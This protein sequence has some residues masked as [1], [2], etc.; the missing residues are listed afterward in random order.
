MA[1][2]LLCVANKK[3]KKGIKVE[4]LSANPAVITC[5]ANDR[6]YENIFSEQLNAKG[7]KGDLLLILSG[8]GNSKNVIKAIRLAKKRGLN[9]SQYLVLMEESVKRYQIKLFIIK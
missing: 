4:S 5:I 8:S 2:D 1:N 3:T 6:G 9:H 7:N